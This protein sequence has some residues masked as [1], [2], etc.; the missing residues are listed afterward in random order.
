MIVCGDI[1][2][3][4]F[5]LLELFDKGGPVGDKKYLFLGDYVERGYHSTETVLLLFI[6]KLLNPNHLFLLRGNHECRSLT[7]IYG[8]YDE[9]FRKY[10]NINPWKT[11]TKTFQ[12]LPLAAVIEGTSAS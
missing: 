2:G 9:V 12:F 1:H 6:Y 7:Q 10:G 4:F 3:Q 5:D 8:F 11:I